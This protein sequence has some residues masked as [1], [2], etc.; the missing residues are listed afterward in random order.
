[1]VVGGERGRRCG[2]AKHDNDRRCSGGENP[3]HSESPLV[4]KMFWSWC[5]DLSA[6]IIRA[7]RASLRTQLAAATS[8]ALPCSLVRA[9]VVSVRTRFAWLRPSP[10]SAMAASFVTRPRSRKRKSLAPFH[11]QRNWSASTSSARIDRRDSFIL[12]GLVQIISAE[13]EY[14]LQ[15]GK[16]LVGRILAAEPGCPLKLRD[17]RIERT[18]L[19]V[20]G[21]EIAQARVRLCADP[22]G[23]GEGSSA[24]TDFEHA[25]LKSCSLLNKDRCLQTLNQPGIHQVTI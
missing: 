10:F 20:R 19:V 24:K 1:M 12:N 22:L 25:L 6:P 9:C 18:V 23:A 4:K 8:P 13:G 17:A 2:D 16:P 7:E 5:G 11:W 3:R 14:A 21:A 15:L